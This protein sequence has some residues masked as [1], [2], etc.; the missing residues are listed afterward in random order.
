VGTG[1][2]PTHWKLPEWGT[3]RSHSHKHIFKHEKS[4]KNAYS[5]SSRCKQFYY[6]NLHSQLKLEGA[7]D[8][9]TRYVTVG[10]YET[11]E[12]RGL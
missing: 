8:P 2:N 10:L 7:I 1:S 6:T 12:I 5:R 4:P 11:L 3:G 9:L